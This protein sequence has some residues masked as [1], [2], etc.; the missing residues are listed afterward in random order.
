MIEKYPVMN[1]PLLERI[2]RIEKAIASLE[3]KISQ[4]QPGVT[5]HQITRAIAAY[6][7]MQIPDPWTDVT[8]NRITTEAKTIKYV[9]EKETDGQA[10]KR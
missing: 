10:G 7:R 1:G 9:V 5:L 2:E 4:I 3:H 8:W 6:S